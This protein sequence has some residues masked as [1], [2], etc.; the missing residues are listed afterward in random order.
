VAGFNTTFDKVRTHTITAQYSGDATFL[1]NSENLPLKVS[2]FAT[3]A[4]LAAPTEAAL[5]STVTL[6]ATISSAG[7]IP[8][9]EVTFADGRNTTLGTSPVDATGVAVLRIN[10]LAAGDHSLS[11]AYSGDGKFASSTSP[12]VTL[13]VTREDFSVGANPPT[14]TV[15]AGQSTQFRLWVTPA[16]GFTGNVAFSCSPLPGISCTFSPATVSSTNGA[17]ST[18]L[19]VTTSATVSHYGMVLPGIIGPGAFL[20]ALALFMFAAWRAKG[21]RIVRIAL[22]P[23]SAAAVIVAMGLAIGGCGG[24]SKSAQPN[25]GTAAV[26]VTA[27]SGAIS[28]TTTINIT[29][30]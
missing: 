2:G 22:L 9:G 17:A 29:V 3:R 4:A 21:I 25:H 1:P 13:T 30:Q 28:H 8:T 24:Y 14:A 27:R 12:S 6:T 15:T 26:M 18:M 16:G 7:G 10:T 20:V 11:A 19:T 5:N 23:T